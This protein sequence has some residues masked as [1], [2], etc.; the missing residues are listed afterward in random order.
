MKSI[1]MTEFGDIDVFQEITLPKPTLKAGHVLIKVLAT[2]VNPL[3][4]KMRKG[5]FPDLVK[6][7]P[8]V[9]H[10]DVAGIIEQVGDGV[11]NLSVGDEVYGCV[12]GLLDMGGALSEYILA[13][14][15]LVAK[16]P[17][18]LSFAEAAALPLVAL[19]A[20]E[21]LVTYANLQRD[22]TVLIHG[23]TGGVGHIAIQLAKWLG[24][25]VFATCS[26]DFKMDIA[27]KLGANIAI[28]YKN[29]SVATY[30]KE[31][32]HDA[33]FN[34]VFDTVGGE[35]LS[36]SFGAASLFGKVVTILAVGNYDL[37]PAFLK[38]LTLHMVMQPLPL[39][40]GIKRNHYHSILTQIA[41]LVDAGAIKPL[42][43]EKK[44]TISQVGA[45]HAYLENGKAVGKVVMTS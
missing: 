32:T 23:G 3:D 31:H 29:T 40:T 26:S 42:I 17:K 8:M 37:T 24:A 11:K 14:A 41:N 5:F 33:G 4:Y 35:N 15:N 28:N 45:A 19:T 44:F 22:Q 30:T 13:D 2:S 27:K 18:S 38:G 7:F 6:S 36:N 12:G 9:L 10:G 1:V 43:D 21:G 16:K 39:I 20:W 25:K 34:V